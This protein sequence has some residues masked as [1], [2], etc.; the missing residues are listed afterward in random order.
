MD[1]FLIAVEEGQ[2][3]EVLRMVEADPTLL[4]RDRYMDDNPLAVAARHEQVGVVRVLLQHMGGE[5][6]D[7]WDEGGNT[8]LHYAAA[9]G[10]Q[11]MA[12]DLLRHGAQPMS[13]DETG[14]VPLM[15]AAARGHLPVVQMLLQ[16]MGGRG[17]DER[18][19][20]GNDPDNHE[21]KTALHCSA[22]WGQAEVVRFL[23]L[24]GADPSVKDKE[25]RHATHMGRGG[26]AEASGTGADAGGPGSD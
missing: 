11:G 18:N 25:K 17:V 20:G 3:A 13:R 8:A 10:L 15:C 9:G 7:D 14:Y 5:G 6:L 26:R 12:A 22:Y 21:G 1:D 16:H 23:L 2:E 24:A 4:Q 19:Q